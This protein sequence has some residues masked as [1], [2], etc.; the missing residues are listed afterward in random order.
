MREYAEPTI[1]AEEGG[2]WDG[3]KNYDHPAY[4][5]ASVARWTTGGSHRMFGSDLGHSSGLTIRVSTAAMR[6][7]LSNDWIHDTGTIVEFDMSESQWA[8]FVASVGNGGGVP[9]TLS[10]YNSGNML[11]APMIAEPH[12]S[13]KELH[14]VEMA[15]RL[16]KALS[17]AREQVRALGAMID[18]GQIGKRELRKIHETLERVVSQAPGSVQFIYE[19]FAEATEKVVD[20]AKTEIEAHVNGVALRLGMESLRELA[21]RL[22]EK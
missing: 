13:K 20:D 10:H 12:L 4:G 22:A 3:A 8:R 16:Q 7:G 6:R 5:L 15:E 17:E 1:T 18:E 21:P 14:G 11:H 19:Q 9:V 2:P